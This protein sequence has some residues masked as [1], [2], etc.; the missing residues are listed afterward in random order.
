MALISTKNLIAPL[1]NKVHLTS[2]ILVAVAFAAVRFAGG[3]VSVQRTHANNKPARLE[4]NARRAPLPADPEQTR[5][6]V[7]NLRN[8]IGAGPLEKPSA[9]PSK[10]QGGLSEIETAVG[11]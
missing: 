5:R 3:S 8:S 2:L 4:E 1:T 6:A 9:A 7:N 10:K 11:L